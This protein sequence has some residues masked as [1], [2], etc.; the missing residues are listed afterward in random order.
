MLSLRVPR[1][2]LEARVLERLQ[3]LSACH[4]LSLGQ[5]SVGAST[6]KPRS[7]QRVDVSTPAPSTISRTCPP[8]HAHANWKLSVHRKTCTDER[9]AAALQDVVDR[10]LRDHRHSPRIRSAFWTAECWSRPHL[11]PDFTAPGRTGS[12]LVDL[13]PRTGLPRQGSRDRLTPLRA[14]T[15]FNLE[16]SGPAGP[17]SDATLPLL[18]EHQSCCTLFGAEHSQSAIAADMGRPVSFSIQ[19]YWP[20]GFTSRNTSSPRG[21]IMKSIAPYRRPAAF[22]KREIMERHSG[23]SSST[24]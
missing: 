16:P 9:E 24:E 3:H 1:H 6:P 8:R 5:R 4:Q 19:R 15:Y 7:R 20:A 2:R 10:R 21:V 13:R 12:P 22:I 14:L 11:E 23:R 18:E 17:R